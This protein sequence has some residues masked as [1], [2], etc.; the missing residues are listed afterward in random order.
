M[1]RQFKYFTTMHF[2][3]ASLGMFLF[4]SA[5]DKE[6]ENREAFIYK[7]RGEWVISQFSRAYLPNISYEITIVLADDSIQYYEF[8][9]YKP[10]VYSI[11]DPI[12]CT[13][14]FIQNMGIW[15]FI[16]KNN[17][18]LLETQDYCGKTIKYSIEI[19][20]LSFYHDPL[21]PSPNDYWMHANI[22]L[23]SP[24]SAIT[25]ED[26]TVSGFDNFYF[27]IQDGDS[28]NIF[29]GHHI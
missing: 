2:I 6:D 5:C 4:Q 13:L 1:L 19:N 7:T 26:F 14:P 17:D 28:S 25:I 3:I 15:N 11:D 29:Y 10:D 20:T 12:L 22:K 18:L 24:D 21:A 9:S 27:V 16:E 8:T 23:V